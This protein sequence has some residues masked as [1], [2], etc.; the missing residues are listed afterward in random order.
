[1]GKREQEGGNR[2]G[3]HHRHEY[4][5]AAIAIGPYSEWHPEN[6]PG[7]DRGCDQQAEFCFVEAELPFDPDANDREDCPDSKAR[8]EGQC[9]HAQN[10]RGSYV[11]RPPHLKA[12]SKIKRSAGVAAQ[13]CALRAAAIGAGAGNAGGRSGR[14]PACR[15]GRGG[16]GFGIHAQAPPQ[17]KNRWRTPTCVGRSVSGVA[18][19]PGP[20]LDPEWTVGR[21][22]T[23][24]LKQAN[25]V[26]GMMDAVFTSAAAPAIPFSRRQANSSEAPVCRNI[27]PAAHELCNARVDQLGRPAF[28][29]A[30]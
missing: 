30:R 4:Q 6:R 15:S 11:C 22:S 26:P 18:G 8:G 12:L 28:N 21:R 10:L 24:T 9:A 2:R 3:E 13:E 25:S 1:V 7:Q 27:A 20:S 29:A 19:C 16:R 14:R 17:K 23:G 5:A